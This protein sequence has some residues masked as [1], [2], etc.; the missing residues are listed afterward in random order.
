MCNNVA[1][2]LTWRS[3]INITAMN[4]LLKHSVI[5]NSGSCL[6]NIF[7]ERMRRNYYNMYQL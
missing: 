5:L 1:D 7:S 2:I 6:V 4:V 3:D